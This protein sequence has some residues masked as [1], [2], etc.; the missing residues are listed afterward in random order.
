MLRRLGDSV[1][2]P[3]GESFSGWVQQGSDLK[4]LGF[5]VREGFIDALDVLVGQL[6]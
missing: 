4:E 2:P 5:F 1:A 6:L 3:F